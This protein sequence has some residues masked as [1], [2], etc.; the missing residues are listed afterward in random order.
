[1]S[2]INPTGPDACKPAKIIPAAAA[3]LSAC[4]R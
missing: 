1:M 2:E 4:L 3:R